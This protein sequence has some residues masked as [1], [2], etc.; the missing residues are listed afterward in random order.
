MAACFNDMPPQPILGRFFYTLHMHTIKIKRI[1]E[2]SAAADGY[3]VL[4]DRLW[5]RGIKKEAAHIHNWEKD[6]APSQELRKWFGHA[7]DKWESFKKKYLA[8]LKGSGAVDHLV[9]ELQT[10]KTVTLLYGARDEEHNNA[11]VL[12]EFL[13]KGVKGF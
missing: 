1:Y 6:V 8:E 10:H 9:D 2:P 12:R 3:R 4:V 11:V 7:P 13:K 5:P